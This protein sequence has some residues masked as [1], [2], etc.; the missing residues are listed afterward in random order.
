[1]D[2]YG[3]DDDSPVP[4]SALLQLLAQICCCNTDPATSSGGSQQMMWDQ[5]VWALAA[6]TETLGRLPL[7]ENANTRGCLYYV[8]RRGEG[9]G[10]TDICTALEE[11]RAI[12]SSSYFFLSEG[13]TATQG[14]EEKAVCVQRAQGPE[15]TAFNLAQDEELRQTMSRR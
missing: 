12:P 11:W 4:A 15:I 2:L 7:G 8:Q 13:G 3:E 1:V 14:M 6:A 5:E 9:G 10:V